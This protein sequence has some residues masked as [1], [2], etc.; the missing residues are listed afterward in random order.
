[1]PSVVPINDGFV[2]IPPTEEEL[3][4]AY[5]SSTSDVTDLS[6]DISSESALSD[7]QA[8][9]NSVAGT[10]GGHPRHPQYYFQGDDSSVTFLVREPTPLSI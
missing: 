8:T 7:S 10:V 2:V 6:S 1:M 5:N 3:P 9:T 4:Y